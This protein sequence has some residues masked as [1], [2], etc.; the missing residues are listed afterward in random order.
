M[1]LAHEKNA[2][3]AAVVLAVAVA[4]AVAAAAGTATGDSKRRS[5]PVLGRSK[6]RQH[7]AHRTFP[8]YCFVS[9][10]LRPGTGA[11]RSRLHSQALFTGGG[12]QTT[13]ARSLARKKLSRKTIEGLVFARE[14]KSLPGALLSSKNQT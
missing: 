10:L 11:L 12:G 3:P 8:A 13:K 9:T 7:L 4:V 14:R 6:V 1:K 2:R 5:A